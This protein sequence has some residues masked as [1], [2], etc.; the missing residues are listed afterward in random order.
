MRR[1]AWPTTRAEYEE[2]WRTGVAEISMNDEV[3][4]YLTALCNL[5]FLEVRLGRM[6]RAIHRV[7]GTPFELVTRGALPPEFRDVMRYPWTPDDQRRFDRYPR[8]VRRAGAAG[9]LPL[10]ST[11]IAPFAPS[12]FAVTAESA[13]A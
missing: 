12:G 6:G 2:L 1:D 5:G 9:Y 13:V 10:A 8:A 4:D 7:P 11:L 3:R